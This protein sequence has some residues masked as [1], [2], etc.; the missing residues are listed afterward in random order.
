MNESQLN[1]STELIIVRI[2]ALIKLSVISKKSFDYISFYVMKTRLISEMDLVKQEYWGNEKE[3]FS[4][5]SILDCPFVDEEEI[6]KSRFRSTSSVVSITEG[7]VCSFI[8]NLHC[9]CFFFS[10][11]WMKCRKETEAY[12]Q[13]IPFWKCGL[14]GAGGFR[15]KVLE[16]RAGGWNTGSFYKTVVSCKEWRHWGEGSK[17]C[18]LG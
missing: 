12:A 13:K 3:Q 7:S 2:P 10:D 15:E 18:E 16:V 14:T 9:F 6:Y 11:K 17:S 8:I 5:V 4:P 1:Y